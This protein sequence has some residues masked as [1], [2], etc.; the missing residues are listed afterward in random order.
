MLIVDSIAAFHE[1]EGPIGLSMGTFDGL[2]VGHQKLVENLTQHCREN[3][4]RS[5]VYTYSNHPREYTLGMK[6]PRIITLEDKIA[7]FEELGVDVLVLLKFDAL[8]RDMSPEHFLKEL[9]FDPLD[10]RYVTVGFDF[11]FGKRAGGT[12][13][14]LKDYA[15]AKKVVLDV[16]EPISR[17]GEKVSST[18]IRNLLFEGNVVKVNELLGRRYSFT[19]EVVH[20]KHVGRLLGFP[21]ANLKIDETMNLI[22]SGVYISKVKLGKTYYPAV[23]NVGFNPTFDQKELNVET[24]ILGIDEKLYGRR[25]KVEFVKRL[26]SE[27]KFENKDALIEQ[28]RRDVESAYA[29]FQFTS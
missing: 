8:Q 24:Y 17:Y 4:Y 18:L 15:E 6:V 9:L 16:V 1:I 13:D 19:G 3:G 14:M 26:R 23:T 10:I 29:Y 22:K 20:G 2:H 21:T 5:V 27:M 7:L 11:H 25:I 28:M 12:V